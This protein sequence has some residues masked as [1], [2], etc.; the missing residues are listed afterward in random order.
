MRCCRSWI[1]PGV[2]VRTLGVRGWMAFFLFVGYKK[3]FY[4]SVNWS[5][6][7]GVAF[8]NRK[9]MVTARY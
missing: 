9:K 1:R 5:G 4:G 2:L 7:D 6:R 3:S 8:Y